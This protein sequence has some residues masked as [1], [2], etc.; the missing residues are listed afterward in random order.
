MMEPRLEKQLAV[1]A[2]I[3]RRERLW[4]ELTAAW[5]VVLALGIILLLLQTFTGRHWPL[6]W[7]I[8]VLGGLAVAAPAWRRYRARPEGFREVVAA[9]E[10]EHPELRHL[11]SAASEQEPDAASGEFRYLQLRAIEAV[12]EH[13]RRHHWREALERKLS[14]AGTAHFAALAG[15]LVVLL[16]LGRNVSQT[17]F[18][19]WLAPEVSVTPGDTLVERGSSLVASARFGRQAPPEATLVVASASGK[20][21]RIPMERHLADPVFGASLA[22]ISEEGR[23]HVEFGS[24]KSGDFKV[25]V[26]EYP[27]LLR[28]DAALRFPDYTGLTNKTILDTRRVSAI[29]GTRLTYS[30]QLNK[31]VTNAA[32]LSTNGSLNLALKDNAIALLSDFVISNSTRY[33][34]VLQDAEGRSNKFP[35]D[36]VIQALANKPP[37]LKLITPSGD[38][39]VSKLE[40]LQLQAEAR[41]EFGLLNYGI[42]FGVAGQDPRIVELGQPAPRNEMRQFDYL[43]RLETLPLEPDQVVSYFV[44]A[45]DRGPDGNVR[46]TYSDMFFAEIRPFEETFRAGQSGDSAGGQQGGGQQEGNKADELAQMQKEIVIA[47]WKLQRGKPPKKPTRS[48]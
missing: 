44:W 32:L 19:S 26:F 38:Q 1:L 41:G 3:R 35:A 43:L 25:G 10:L 21:R 45:D 22:D 13:P 42:G 4:R 8:P 28:A 24:H 17:V 5:L 46:R 12:L 16:L 15:A 31:P 33:S 29:E 47:T 40:E 7:I 6:A 20:T 18:R 14:S 34:L 30:F 39:R 27:S 48:P 9:L 2:Q 36:V 37:E 23:Y 11:L